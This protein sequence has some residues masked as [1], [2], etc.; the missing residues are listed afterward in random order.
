MC[1]CQIVGDFF[2]CPTGFIDIVSHNYNIKDQS[3]YYIMEDSP[4]EVVQPQFDY[5]ELYYVCSE[6]QQ[7]WYFEC[8][9][10]TPSFPIFGIKLANIK[11]ILSQNKINSIKQFLVILA[12][13]GF[14]EKKCIHRGCM[15]YSLNGTKVCL[16]HFG[17]KFSIN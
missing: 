3:S 11:Q 4:C 6:C 2:V 17:Y 7:A 16:N 13:E 1:K 14:S 15:N 8:Y 5:S 9:P 10:E 12:H